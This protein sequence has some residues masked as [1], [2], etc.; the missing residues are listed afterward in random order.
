MPKSEQGEIDEREYNGAFAR[1]QDSLGGM[2]SWDVAAD[3]RPLL[4]KAAFFMGDLRD[5]LPMLNMQA[6]F[7][8][9]TEN[10][11]EKQVGVLF[12][13]FGLSQFLFMAPAGYFLDYS[14]NK[15]NW[16]VFSGA[17]TA[18]LTVMT[19]FIP[20]NGGTNIVPMVISNIIQGALTAV[21]PPGF[22]GIALGIVGSTGF[23]HQVSRNRMMNHVG[24][25]LFVAVGSL[26]AY[27]LYPNI[28][29]LFVVSPIAVIGMYWNLSKILPKHVDRDAARCLIIESPTMTE[30][31]QMDT[32]NSMEEMADETDYIDADEAY[33]NFQAPNVKL[34][35]KYTPPDSIPQE[36]QIGP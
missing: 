8:I 26:I 31:E 23:T 11:T 32:Q 21:F 10:F 25:A 24:S 16:V 15:I 1:S 18:F 9:S 12:L 17:A 22:N 29:A 20:T 5:G 36:L 35:S 2:G 33:S 19:P 14:N 13:A 34:S 3:A 7:L 28:G 4:P 6:A 30:Y 27:F